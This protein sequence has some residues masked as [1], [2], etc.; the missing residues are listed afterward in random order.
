MTT[1]WTWELVVI[2]FVAFFVLL[3]GQMLAPAAAIF[4]PSPEVQAKVTEV[5]LQMAAQV[6][7]YLVS[8]TAINVGLSI[9]M[10]SIYQILG[11]Q[12]AWTWAILL[13]I[14]NYIPYIGPI[15]SLRSAVLRR[16]DLRGQSVA[17]HH[18]DG[19]VLDRDR[20]RRLPDRADV[21]GP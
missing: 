15:L 21:D 7:N 10:G 18:R 8:R 9:I 16:A 14:L 17:C 11:L 4:G 12:Q 13:L 6:R 19:G 2:L 3:E 1:S 20:N 5:L